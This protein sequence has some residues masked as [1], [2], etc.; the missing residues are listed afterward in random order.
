M[1]LSQSQS[2]PII[3][4]LLLLVLL[5][6]ASRLPT[7]AQSPRGAQT[8]TA[9]IQ[10]QIQAT[11]IASGD[12]FG[13]TVALSDDWLAVGAAGAD[14]DGV[15]GGA[16]Y[17][18]QR[19]TQAP[20]GWIET[21]KIDRDP[22][23]LLGRYGQE[24]ALQGD[25]LMV[26][27]PFDPRNGG[28]LQGVVYVY[29]RNQGGSDA[30]GP[31][32]GLA[33]EEE[34]DGRRFGHAVVVDGDLA[35]ASAV[36]A[37]ENRGKVY[38]YSRAGGPWTRIKEIS[39]PNG[40]P[41]DWFG[42]ALALKG[43][44]L[45]VGAYQADLDA[46]TPDTG[47]VFVYGRDEGGP[48]Q[49]GLVARLFADPPRDDSFFGNALALEGDTLLVGAYNE[50]V[51]E[52]DQEVTRDVGAAYVYERNEGGTDAWGL[53]AALRPADGVL[54]D[55][56]GTSVA[57]AGD[58][59]W[60]GVPNRD[61][62]GFGDEGVVFHYRRNEGGANAWGLVSTIE[63][64]PSSRNAIFGSALAA[65]GDTLVSGAPEHN[66]QGAAYVITEVEEPDRTFSTSYLPAA[67]RIWAPPTG[68]LHDSRS[69]E[70]PDGPIIGA[71]P[72]TLT[73][74]LV[75]T[76][77]E[78]ER[79]QESLP[80]G[81]L[82]RGDYYRLSAK[83]LTITPAD[84]PL[85]VG[86]PV[87]A[88]A[89]TNRLAVAAYMPDGLTTEA[90]L[91]E[92]PTRSWTT[93]PGAYDP[94]TNLFVVTVRALLPEGFS[95]VLFEH[96]ENAPLPLPEATALRP[97]QTQAEEYE[98]AC[99]PAAQHKE[100]CTNDTYAQIGDEL[101]A[102]H[103]LFVNT[104]DFRAP[105][106][107]HAAGVF[108]GPD[109]E[110]VLHDVYFGALS[111]GAPCI[112]HAG[113]EIAGEYRYVG[114]QLLVCI[115][116]AW[117]V[118]AIQRTVRHELFHA[119][120][121]FYPNVAEDRINR[122]HSE[123]THWL[124]EGTATAAEKSSFIMLRSPDW[125][126]RP[127]TLPLTSTLA[128]REYETQDFWVFTGLEGSQSDHYLSY[129]RPLFEEGATPEHVD[130]AAT[131]E[132][133]EAYWEWAKN[134]VF[135]HHQ[136]MIDA[137]SSG[138]CQVEQAALDPV[139]IQVLPY[140]ESYYVEGELPPLTSILVE[141][142][143]GVDRSLLPVGAGTTGDPL[144]LRYK[145]YEEYEDGETGCKEIA[146]GARILQNVSAGTKIYVLVANISLT[147]SL[148]YA[149]EVD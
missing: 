83:R 121:A 110:P 146:Y 120:Q 28:A 122:R 93:M 70:S 103:D 108:V 67:M 133:G 66:T 82:P 98:V 18:Y 75:A 17:L 92:A 65:E 87:P 86:L 114:L 5:G 27:V 39:D 72:G 144:D 81:F 53:I 135:E 142:Q 132:L 1:D 37:D 25:T 38:L 45:V 41:F 85:L 77:V 55:R 22:P 19:D 78:T 130:Q 143:V 119:I 136:P 125:N 80:G 95:V 12:A 2:R 69:L 147:D 91:P 149:V 104:L 32:G 64:D 23:D 31:A 117:G 21:H 54:L 47:V 44:T 3:P 11:D 62:G 15:S 6:A 107:V 26:G 112:N 124:V 59:V 76:I 63:A 29:E 100:V 7:S 36:G 61:T 13:S 111:A 131:L 68:T 138:P 56:F 113:D 137:F 33:D 8:V 34:G 84:R 99:D 49:W 16:V 89:D 106:L 148:P 134:Q 116:E 50:G 141:V 9:Y 140:P 96:P 139:P 105:A 145:V 109:K 24:L 48:D 43:D 40:Q 46:T 35:A 20:S 128:L 14:V 74:P 57:L 115:D 90:E 71:V 73:E 51:Y 60:I 94:S 101:E 123:L 88:G 102:A 10:T 52:N 97:A 127:A 42:S 118:D 30:W 126:I 79:P 129:L 58:D 4:L